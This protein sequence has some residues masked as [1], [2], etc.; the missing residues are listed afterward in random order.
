MALEM[1][2]E[3]WKCCREACTVSEV[4]VDQFRAIE[5][6]KHLENFII[7]EVNHIESVKKP[8]PIFHPKTEA[9]SHVRTYKE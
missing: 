5:V 7:Y 2:Q 3:I 1:H 8:S 4:R 9:M 6:N